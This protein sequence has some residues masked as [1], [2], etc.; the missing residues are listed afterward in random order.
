[1]TT[2]K[3][4]ESKHFTLTPLVSGVYACIHKSG[5]AALSNAG[6]IDLGDHTLVVDTLHTLA[7]GRALR[8]AAETLFERPVETVILT[9]AHNDHWMGASAFDATTTLLASKATRQVCVERGAEIVEDFRNPAL[10]QAWLKET[11]GQLQTEQDER[12]RASLENSATFIRYAMAEMGEWQPRYADQTFEEAVT[13][14]GSKRKANLR[15]LGRGHSADDAVLMLPEDGLA[16]IGDVGFFDTQPYLGSCDFDLYRKQM[17]TF[18]GSGFQVLV[19]GH[20]PVGGKEDIA[21]ELKYLDVLEDRVGRVAQRGGSFEE[22]MQITLP[23]P[24][25][26]WLMGGM[27]RFRVNVRYLFA[28]FGGAVPEEE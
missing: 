10:W 28:R 6:I 5:G 22:A 8:Q 12:V 18:Q 19:P 7:A 11:E 13:F 3:L 16:F 24:F 21:L 20:G 15:S 1:M 9:H 26:K 14:K 23:E 2:E 17:R 25:N 4:H 27:E